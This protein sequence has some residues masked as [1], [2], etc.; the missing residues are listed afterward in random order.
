MKKIILYL[1]YTISFASVLIASGIKEVKEWWDIARPFF[2]VWFICLVIALTISHIT[3]I[4]RYTYPILV[5]I[6]AWAYKHKIVMTRFTRNTHRVYKMNNSSYRK[7]FAYTQ[8]M[9]DK[10]LILKD[11]V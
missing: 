1:L 6:S 5:C 8:Y 10:Y 2:A 7:L 3:L 11:I 9:F 4:R